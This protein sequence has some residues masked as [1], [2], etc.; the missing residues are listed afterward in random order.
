M[1]YKVEIK[2]L[3]LV[4]VAY[5]THR[6]LVTE[7]SALFPTVFQSV[8]GKINNIPFFIYHEINAQTLQGVV[9]VC[10]PTAE[11]PDNPAVKTK[12]VPKTRA[13]VTRHIGPYDTIYM[14]YQA[15][16]QYAQANSYKIAGPS[17]E[18]FEKGPN[19]EEHPA[20]FVT[21]VVV[22]LISE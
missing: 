7:A 15:I 8:G 1:D 2:D 9:D 22:P 3:E 14:A 5:M 4:H 21:M 16:N 17:R 13:L 6:G 20:N 19:M 11:E 18:I 12:V 10:E